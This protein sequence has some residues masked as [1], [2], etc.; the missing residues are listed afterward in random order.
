MNCGRTN[1]ET[2][3]GS[4][5][6][7][8]GSAG[9]AGLHLLEGTVHQGG[10][11]SDL[12]AST[13]DAGST[14]RI[15]AASLLAALSAPL[16]RRLPLRPLPALCGPLG[17]VVIVC[18]LTLRI[19]SMQT[20]AAAYSRTL[21]V[22]NEQSV[23]ERGP[24]RHVRHPGYLGSL[25]VWAGFALSSRS[26]VVVGSVTAL[27]LPA[28]KHRMEAEERLLERVL[29]DYESYEGRTRKLVPGVW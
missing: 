12:H 13:E 27:L 21:R 2:P 25:L 10:S 6:F 11:A 22:T 5:W 16:L 14:R 17:L 26:A 15:A 23:I 24:Y 20:L 8:A 4:R 28:Y 1:F 29:P 7:L 18:G 9:V 19:W 3:A